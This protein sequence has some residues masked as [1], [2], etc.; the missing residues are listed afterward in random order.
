MRPDAER[1]ER[2]SAE[3]TPVVTGWTSPSGLPTAIAI[4]LSD[5]KQADADAGRLV[6]FEDGATAQEFGRAATLLAQTA[7]VATIREL[8][9]WT[10][11]FMAA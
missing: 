3:T 5:V 11:K 1:S 6:V 8:P 4:W 10:A 7:H 9:H 2:P